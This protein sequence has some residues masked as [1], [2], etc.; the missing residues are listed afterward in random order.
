M[1]GWGWVVAEA[2][3]VR[4]VPL[5]TVCWESV[6]DAVAL[7]G[8]RVAVFV[9][10]DVGKPVIDALVVSAMS[11]H[12]VGGVGA[13]CYAVEL[14][15]VVSATATGAATRARSAEPV[16]FRARV[17]LVNNG[18]SPVA[19]VPIHARY[20]LCAVTGEGRGGA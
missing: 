13:P 2:V 19:L 18:R 15:A 5:R 11:C 14:T 9:L 4:V 12:D 17:R 3:S 16:N 10:I 20:N 7:V 1:E 6:D 8:G